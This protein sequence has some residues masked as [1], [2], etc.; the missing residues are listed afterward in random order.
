MN[1]L[2]PFACLAALG[3]T[4]AH[5]DE[6]QAIAG[7]PAQQTTR[8]DVA[9]GAA[10]SEPST[11]V[12]PPAA[13]DALVPAVSHKPGTPAATGLPTVTVP[14]TRANDVEQR[15]MSS[16]AKMIVGREE[17]DRNGDSSVG[18]ILKRLPGVTVGGRPGR[19]GDIRMRGMGNGY[20]QMLVNG[21]R[22]PAGFALDSLSP[23]QVERIE[24]VRGPIAEHSTRAIAGTINIILRE[25]YQQKDIQLKLTDAIE[26]NRH[27]AN[28]S[29]TVPG[30]L[31]ALTYLLNGSLFENHQ[32]DASITHNVDETSGGVVT[33]D[34][35][36]NDSS[37]RRARGIHLSPRLSYKFDGGDT[38]TFQPFL[39]SSHSV[40]DNDSVL[41]QS[42]GPLP[43]EYAHSAGDASSSSTFLR[44]FGNWL[45][46]MDGG[47]KLDVKFGFGVGHSDSSGTRNL[48]NSAGS[49]QDVIVDSDATRDHG[50]SLGAK[51]TTPLGK[52]HLL[53]A[54]ADVETGH[55]IQNRVSLD[56][57]RAQFADSGEDLAADTRRMAGFVQDEWDI[58]P[59]WATNL[60]LRWEGIRTTSDTSAGPLVNNSSVWSPVF[61]VVWRIP[62]HDKDQLRWSLTHSYR[63]PT[64]GDLIAVPALSRLNSATR[65]DRIGNPALKPE[66][67][68]GMDMAYE[69]YLG[70]SGILSANV[71]VRDID[72]LMRRET[73]LVATSTGPRWVSQPL[74]IGHARTSGIELEAK[75]QLIELMPDAPNIDFRA[76]YSRFWSHVDGV[77][78]PDNRLDQQPTQTA[79]VGLDYRL[80]GVP[81]TLGGGY[82]WTPAGQI[83]SSLTERVDSD[84]K[85]QVDVYGLWKFSPAAQLRVSANNLLA[86][87]YGSG[88][89]VTTG[90][91]A[92]MATTTARTFATLSIKLELKL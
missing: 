68:T 82:N 79:N 85:R 6:Q 84:A 92:Q 60:G 65:P 24:I 72:D 41:T 10:Q 54:G 75:F 63:S 3:I 83:Q 11:Q 66:L 67:A 20:T 88:R 38:L 69:H 28:V 46:R 5:A 23:D 61:H 22:P 37:D 39:M 43:L 90:E 32:H 49:L 64:I 12:A 57:G 56:N 87:D 80:K 34:Q 18:E 76:N 58:N 1:K 74:N 42:V 17:L 62:E 9:P 47:A 29:L 16:A 53:T 52:G 59:A 2:I 91:L 33:K 14:G 8:S 77:P 78:G 55:R 86:R 4:L 44:G 25:G 73:S 36:V 71:F 19:G 30:K 40:S 50:G 51:Y 31:G 48:F 27:G 70:K 81:L 89:T 26:Q 21:E 7:A 45:H 15:R 35:L 13:A